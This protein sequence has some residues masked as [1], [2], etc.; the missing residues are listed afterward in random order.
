MKRAPVIDI[1]ECSDCGTC[2]ALCPTVFRRNEWSG[3]METEELSEYPEDEI[4]EAI[5]FCPKDCIA[6]D[7]DP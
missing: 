5:N 7:M 3:L 6:W 1:R 2:V 4:R